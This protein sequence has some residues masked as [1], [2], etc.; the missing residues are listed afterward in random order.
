VKVDA[1]L[2]G[3][4]LGAVPERARAI[5]A[6]GYDGAI[7]AELASDP[8]LP[9]ALA[10]EHTRRIDLIT[11]IAVAFARTPMTLAYTA[12]DLNAYSRG[13]LVLGLGSQVQAHIV[14]RFGMPWSRPAARMREFV[15]ALRAIW[16]CW[17]RGVKLEFRGEF[18]QHTLMTP[19]FTPGELA[20][21]PPRVF[22]AAVG[23]RMAEVAAEVADGLIAHAFTTARYLREVTLPAVERG[24]ARAGRRRADF[25]IMAPC[26][27]RVARD[28]R[29][30]EAAAPALR[31]QI[32]FYASTP[33]Y[34][35]VLELHG[36]ESLQGELNRLSKQGQW[37]RMGELIDDE[38]L[39]AFAV[40][41]PPEGLADAILGRCAGVVDRVID[42]FG[43]DAADQRAELLARL[44]AA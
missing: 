41:A 7:S 44:R 12:H 20:A 13:R 2:I 4:G 24:L 31:R 17:Y 15:L 30:L 42:G 3:R 28:A 36:W 23:P 18:Y 38:V 43:L 16:D 40:S 39:D 22:L 5:E 11:S 19:A 33:A 6:A 32:A 29:G 1:G 25:E 35:G 37:E 14:K 9:L 34:R 8:F 21:G 26:F 27:V 10:A